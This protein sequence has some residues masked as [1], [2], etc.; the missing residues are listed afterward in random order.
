MT[1]PRKSSDASG[2]PSTFPVSR[3]SPRT[4]WQPKL[5]LHCF[6]AQTEPGV[7][8]LGSIARVVTSWSACAFVWVPLDA[9]SPR[10]GQNI[11]GLVTN[12][13]VSAIPAMARQH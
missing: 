3:S 1:W 7:C 11:L 9:N 5:V 4:S 8:I 12:L 2:C 13:L 6:S 10:R